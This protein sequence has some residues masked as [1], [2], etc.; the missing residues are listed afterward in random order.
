MDPLDNQSTG[1]VIQNC[2]LLKDIRQ[3]LTKM[4]IHCN[5]G[6]ATMNWMGDLPRYGPVWFHENGIANILSLRRAK[7]KHCVTYDSTDGNEFHMYHQD[8]M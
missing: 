2:K 3:V 6:V 8:G 4:H 1:D 7:E 5:A